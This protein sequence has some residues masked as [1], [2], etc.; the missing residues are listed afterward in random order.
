MQPRTKEKVQD[1]LVGAVHWK[2]VTEKRHFVAQLDQQKTEI[3]GNVVI[4]QKVH[5]AAEAIWRATR[6]SISPR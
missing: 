6:R 5:S 4:Q 3:I 1:H 2:R